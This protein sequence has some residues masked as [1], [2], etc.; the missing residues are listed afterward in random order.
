M[1]WE[2]ISVKLVV[3]GKLGFVIL[4]S[5]ME[6]FLRSK[7]KSLLSSKSITRDKEYYYFVF[8]WFSLLLYL[9]MMDIRITNISDYMKR[10]KKE[11]K[12]TNIAIYQERNLLDHHQSM[13]AEDNNKEEQW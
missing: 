3:I 10:K 1:D 8:D 11:K 13:K 4:G 12:K 2:E 7:F 9:R 5:K 6:M